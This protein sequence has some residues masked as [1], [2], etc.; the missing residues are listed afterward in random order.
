LSTNPSYD[1]RAEDTSRIDIWRS[2]LESLIGTSW[3]ESEWNPALKLFTGDPGNEFTALSICAVEACDVIQGGSTPRMC[4]ACSRD[5]KKLTVDKAEFIAT[6]VPERPN[7][8]PRPNP[9]RCTART[10]ELFCHRPEHVS[11]LCNFHYRRWHAYR[12]T[13]DE[14][15]GPTEW[16]I[17]YADSM[18]PP[19]EGPLCTVPACSKQHH[20]HG[21]CSIHLRW[22][23]EGNVTDIERWAARQ[24]P[25]LSSRYFSLAPVSDTIALEIIRGLQVRD[26]RGCTIYVEAIR[27]LVRQ[28]GDLESLA[29]L[30]RETALDLAHSRKESNFTSTTLDIVRTIQSE[31]DDL[32]GI[33][34]LSKDH[35]DLLRAGI[36]IASPTRYTYRRNSHYLDLAILSQPWLQRCFREWLRE[37]IEIST[38]L[39][40]KD[41]QMMYASAQV[42]SESLSERPDN[43]NNIN[44]LGALD[45][46]KILIACSTLTSRKDK[47]YARHV[48]QRRF[49]DFG[50]LLE[51]G[52]SR[53]LIPSIHNGFAK[54]PRH[55]VTPDEEVPEKES[56]AMP[57]AAIKVLNENL[58]SFDGTGRPNV[59]IHPDLYAK[60]LQTIFMLL[61]D[62]GRR[63]GEIRSLKFDCLR[64]DGENYLLVWDNHKTRKYNRTL[65][66]LD[67]TAEIVKAWISF[68]STLEPNWWSQEYLFPAPYEGASA[69]YFES[70]DFTVCFRK[71]IDRFDS[72]PT[73]EH[74]E[75]GNPIE[76]DR[77]KLNSYSLRHAYAQRFADSG[78][79]VVVLKD[80]MDHADVATTLGYFTISEVRKREA[81]ET[82]AS[83]T[84]G[85]D[86]QRIDSALDGYEIQTV[87]VP[88]GRCTLPSNVRAGGHGCPTR[89]MC[90]GCNH[91]RSDPSFLPQLRQA[92]GDLKANLAEATAAG[93]A[94]WILDASV[95]ELEGYKNII[96]VL[97][98]AVEELGPAE[99]EELDRA[100]NSLQAF[101]SSQLIPLEVIERTMRNESSL[102]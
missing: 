42:A 56:R 58:D 46:R 55:T 8:L 63:P 62:T 23:K 20:S 70:Q 76:C 36:E 72:I 77:L 71:W 80:L 17:R 33:D 43:G 67:Q 61:R 15:L 69:A 45:M 93:S 73:G 54:T 3:R 5:F 1:P 86:G 50:I 27:S 52:R 96:T 60:A 92:V 66:I 31:H 85:R 91:F 99:R 98:S 29:Q 14:H 21:L 16:S 95:H 18:P 24:P 78:I 13:A 84:F 100:T 59:D 4:T 75:F 19:G 97:E 7:R 94:T 89:F 32:F 51:F 30:D 49:A 48:R 68:R 57:E 82:A 22:A 64:R 90:S 88:Y 38:Q 6:Y 11:G 47:L 37:T 81:T 9:E 87:S 79:D 10:G 34:E 26:Q 53:S 25:S 101:R 12:R 83:L 41:I 35:I 2:H 40:N 102:E 44:A 74:D 39:R 65:P 28:V